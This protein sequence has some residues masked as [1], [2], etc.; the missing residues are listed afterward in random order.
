[1]L[2]KATELLNIFISNGYEAYIVGGFVRDSILGKQSLDIDICTNA[3]PKQIQSIF[4]DVKLPFEQYGAVNLVYK[5]IT[6][7]ITTY[8]MDLE[9]KDNRF[10]SKIVYTDN[11]I[12]D[13]KRRDFTMNT[14]CI[15][16]NGNIIDK[17]NNI[18]DI[19]NHL[20]KCVGDAN[21]KLQEDA[22]RILRAIR[23]ATILDFKIDKELEI[24][25]LN[26]RFLLKDLSYYRKKQELNKIFSSVNALKGIELIK[27]YKLEECLNIN[28]DNNIV[29]TNDP[30]GMWV[31]V[32]PCDK[33]QFTSNEQDY[34][35]AIRRVVKDKDINDIELYRNGNYVCYIAA[36]I[37]GIDAVN[38]YDRYDNLPITKSS[39][40]NIT[41][42]QIIDMLKLEDKS[43]TKMIFKDIEDKIV[44]KRLNNDYESIKKYLI[45]NYKNDIL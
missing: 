42:K 12:I 3:T 2:E 44:S 16:N 26:N 45:D 13:L 37:L 32:N 14:L 20:I 1:M 30:I 28:I 21:I 5:K 19:K 29:K 7:E 15:D 40:V 31:Q 10:P 17:L 36:Q 43:L 6:F 27:Q 35:N 11:L 39:D 41:Q 33:Y 25:I 8:R 24:A 9:Y 23:F 34:I 4:K 18:N 38:I 22:L